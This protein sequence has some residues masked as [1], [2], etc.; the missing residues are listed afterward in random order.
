[1]SDYFRE[2][3]RRRSLWVKIEE[4]FNKGQTLLECTLLYQHLGYLA[5]IRPYDSVIFEY[6]IKDMRDTYNVIDIL[7]PSKRNF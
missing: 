7:S 3:G 5:S 6:Q 2:H 1:M 4:I